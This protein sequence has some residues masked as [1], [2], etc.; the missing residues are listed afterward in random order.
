MPTDLRLTDAGVSEAVAEKL[1]EAA[2]NSVRQ[3]YDRLRVDNSG[4]LRRYLDLSQADFDELY[5][6]VE[7]LIGEEYPEDRLARIHPKVH[8]RGV[9]VQRLDDPTR[10]KFGNRSDE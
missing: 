1:N 2:I 3:L 7:Q 6:R 10:P 5:R 9:A 8:K 4:A